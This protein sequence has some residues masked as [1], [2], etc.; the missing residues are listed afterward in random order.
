MRDQLKNESHPQDLPEQKRRIPG[1]PRW[2]DGNRLLACAELTNLELKAMLQ[3]GS[4][5]GYKTDGA[6]YSPYFDFY[7]VE[8][9]R[10]YLM[11]IFE[12]ETEGRLHLGD[13][14][15]IQCWR[16]L[17]RKDKEEQNEKRKAPFPCPP[18][19]EWNEVWLTLVDEDTVRIETPGGKGRFTYHELGMKN[20]R[21][22]NKEGDDRTALWTTLKALCKCRGEISSDTPMHDR[23]PSRN[24]HDLN[25]HM[26]KLFGIE[27]SIFID[28]YKRAKGYH[29]KVRLSDQTTVCNPEE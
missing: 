4:L 6:L 9:L 17:Y 29:T 18:G 10:F 16:K 19:T 13:S 26:Q 11:D 12:L 25:K 8:A 23:R 5:R 27:D 20:K 1:I 2:I 7:S 28:H 15:D 22:R 21:G 3:E 14:W 24:M